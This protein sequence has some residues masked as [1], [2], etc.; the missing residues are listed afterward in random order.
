MNQ[1]G[2]VK[3]SVVGEVQIAMYLLAMFNWHPDGLKIAAAQELRNLRKSVEKGGFQRRFAGPASKLAE[4][5]PRR[6]VPAEE[7]G[8][9]VCYLFL[10]LPDSLVH[11]ALGGPIRVKVVF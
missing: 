5:M 3:D 9:C 11:C 8:M 7:L 2:A 10:D 6:T 4:L 1:A